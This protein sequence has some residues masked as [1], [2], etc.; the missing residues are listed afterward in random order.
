MHHIE[1][2]IP[3][4]KMK[5]ITQKIVFLMFLITILYDSWDKFTKK[6]KDKNSFK[7]WNLIL[8]VCNIKYDKY[9]FKATILYMKTMKTI[10]WKQIINMWK[11]FVFLSFYKKRWIYYKMRIYI[12]DFSPVLNTM[13]DRFNRTFTLSYCNIT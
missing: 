2:L 9:K 5:L 6:K 13:I 3:N 10:I 12:I 7:I 4:V 1:I 11:I 8:V